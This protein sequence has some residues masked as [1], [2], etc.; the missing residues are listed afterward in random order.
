MNRLVVRMDNIGAF[1]VVA[2]SFFCGYFLSSYRA[3]E[4]EWVN[5]S[6]NIV[7]PRFV[8]RVGVYR[9]LNDEESRRA[10]QLLE[11]L[12]YG[13]LLLIDALSDSDEIPMES[14]CIV[15]SNL[16]YE[17]IEMEELR[18]RAE[19]MDATCQP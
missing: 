17:R 18:N 3:I 9:L 2:L 7:V 14:L 19:E 16:D 13:D 15:L 5:T 10:K 1:L 6:R 8:E 4:T 11:S 12:V